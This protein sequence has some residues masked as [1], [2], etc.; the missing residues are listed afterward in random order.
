[1]IQPEQA[2]GAAAGPDRNGRQ[3]AKTFYPLKGVTGTVEKNL[4]RGV[5][6]VNTDVLQCDC[7]ARVNT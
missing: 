1:M 3:A 2:A 6:R 4:Q 5:D 7:P